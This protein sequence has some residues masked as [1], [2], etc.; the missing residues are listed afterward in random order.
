VKPRDYNVTDGNADWTP[1]DE[2][3]PEVWDEINASLDEYQAKLEKA[4]LA[5][6]G[7]GGTDDAGAD[8]GDDDTDYLA[9]LSH[10]AFVETEHPRA[11]KGTATGGQFV[12]QG[13]GGGAAGEHLATSEGPQL[14]RIEAGYRELLARNAPDEEYRKLLSTGSKEPLRR[15]ETWKGRVE[16]FL[17]IAPPAVT[18]AGGKA[19]PQPDAA[20]KV[21]KAPS[22]AGS[23][24]RRMQALAEKGLREGADP[25]ELGKQ[26]IEMAGRYVHKNTTKYANLVLRHIEDA[27]GL[28]AGSLGTATTRP[29][30]NRSLHIAK[31]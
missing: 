22:Y 1:D 15:G 10:D 8:D 11:A 9:A 2:A 4:L 7:G 21:P 17:K 23:G 31:E 25:Q 3:P 13:A 28:K 19:K 5:H 12:A 27:H 30:L 6:Y 26:I 20:A 14:P 29:Y 24:E 16:S 18:P